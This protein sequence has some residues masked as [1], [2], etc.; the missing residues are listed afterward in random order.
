M[1]T[2]KFVETPDELLDILINEDVVAEIKISEILYFDLKSP[3]GFSA[4]DLSMNDI[5]KMI[6]NSF[7]RLGAVVHVK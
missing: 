6:E 5:C 2:K 3:D 4:D 7:R 1:K